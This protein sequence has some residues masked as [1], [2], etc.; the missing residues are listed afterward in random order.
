MKNLLLIA[1]IFL[2]FSCKKESPSATVLNTV[3]DIKYYYQGSDY[4]YSEDI[5]FNHPVTGDIVSDLYINTDNILVDI[6]QKATLQQCYHYTFYTLLKKQN[7][8][9]VIDFK[10]NVYDVN[11]LFVITN[12]DN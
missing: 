8:D 10:L 9:T 3:T 4:Y 12:W 5:Y 2:A 6:K 7:A 1:L 11:Y